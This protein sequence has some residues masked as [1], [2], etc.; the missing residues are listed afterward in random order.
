M[1]EEGEELRGESQEGGA[2]AVL[3]GG[4]EGRWR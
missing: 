3:R 2:R 1:R 4:G